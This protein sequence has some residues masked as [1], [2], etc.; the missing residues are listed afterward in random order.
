VL[1]VFG[2]EEELVIKGYNDANFQTDTD[3][4]KSQ[5]GFTFCLNEGAMR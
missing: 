1:L 4:T 3:D 5:Y 2:G